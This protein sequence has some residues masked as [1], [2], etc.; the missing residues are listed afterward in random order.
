VREAVPRAGGNLALF[1]MRSSSELISIEFVHES[2]S[3]DVTLMQRIQQYML[4]T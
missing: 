4:K 3:L 2:A 1:H